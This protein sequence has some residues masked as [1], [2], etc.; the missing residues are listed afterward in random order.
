MSIIIVEHLL[1]SSNSTLR[2]VPTT[3]LNWTSSNI[4]QGKSLIIDSSSS[5]VA[6]G[7]LRNDDLNFLDSNSTIYK[8]YPYL[9]TP[10]ASAYGAS[11]G[12]HIGK[13]IKGSR[14]SYQS[15]ERG[16]FLYPIGPG[17]SGGNDMNRK[18]IGG[19]GGGGLLLEF[20]NEMKIDGSIDVSGNSPLSVTANNGGGGGGGGAGGSLFIYSPLATLS[21]NGSLLANGGNGSVS[22]T[23]TFHSGSG[24]GGAIHVIVCFDNFHGIME[25]K[26]GLTVRFPDWIPNEQSISTTIY[27]AAMGLSSLS[28]TV[29]YLR[30]LQH[31]YA[32]GSGIVIRNSQTSH[33]LSEEAIISSC[34]MNSTI[35]F[36]LPSHQIELGYVSVS[37]WVS[38]NA[39]FNDHSN[40]SAAIQS[41]I[42]HT[43]N[44]LIS[45]VLEVQPTILTLPSVRSLNDLTIHY[46][47]CQ[48]GIFNITGTGNIQIHH[49]HGNQAC[50]I[51]FYENIM[52]NAG[53]DIILD[54]LVVAFND[55]T[56]LV[57][58][59]SLTI[60]NGASLLWLNNNL[61]LFENPISSE[62]PLPLFIENMKNLT[63]SSVTIQDSSSLIGSIL[64]IYASFITIARNSTISTTGRGFPGGITSV[65]SGEV[66]SGKGYGRGAAGENGGNGG[67][68]GGN[69][70]RGITGLYEL[71]KLDHYNGLSNNI[72]TL[73]NNASTKDLGANS[74]SYGNIFSPY[75]P[76]SGGG[77]SETGQLSV[78]GAGGGVIYISLENDLSLDESCSIEANGQFTYYG[79]GGGAGGSIWIRHYP[80]D[81]SSGIEKPSPHIVYDGRIFGSGQIT[82][83]GGATCQTV[84][85]TTTLDYPGGVGGGGRIRIEKVLAE[86]DGL[87]SARSGYQNQTQQLIETNKGGSVATLPALTT[88]ILNSSVPSSSPDV[89]DVLFTSFPMFSIQTITTLGQGNGHRNATNAKDA[90]VK[91]YWFIGYRGKIA[92]SYQL[93]SQA[94]ATEVKIALQ[95]LEYVELMNIGIMKRPSTQNG[96]IWSITFYDFIDM[97]AP[98]YVDYYQLYCTQGIPTVKV[99]YESISSVT[100]AMEEDDSPMIYPKEIMLSMF[101]LSNSSILGNNSYGLWYKPNVFR[102]Y[103]NTSVD[104]TSQLEKLYVTQLFPVPG[105]HGNIISLSPPY[106]LKSYIPDWN[107]PTS[108]PSMQPSSQPSGIPTMQPSSQPTRQPSSQPSMV[109]STQPSSRPSMQPSTQP[110]S[111]PSSQP[112]TQPTMQPSTQPTSQPSLQPFS[113][114]TS[115]PSR[116]PTAQPTRQPSSQPSMV[117][118]AQPSSRPSM[119]PSTQPSSRPSSQPSTHPT[120]QP[121]TQPTSQPSRQPF[122]HPTGQPSA[123]PVSHPTGQP[124]SQPTSQPSLQPFSHPT[125]QPSNQ[126]SSRPSTQPSSQP[127]MVPSA[128]P[129]SRPSMQPSSQPSMVPSTQPSSLP[130]MIPS[131]QPS[132]NPTNPS[133]QPSSQVSYQSFF[134]LIFFYFFPLA[135]KPHVPTEFTG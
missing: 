55:N 38:L 26:G 44:P 1:L 88:F 9:G 32:G 116:Q 45:R 15:M 80:F 20:A 85:C 16:N 17:G 65:F 103:A 39:I 81:G 41:S 77:S 36:G 47:D 107:F 127:S 4:I 34:S 57:S 74:Q 121:S 134:L 67:G 87:I 91:G 13:G 95:S 52:V 130:S 110:S 73:L 53:S 133:G 40:L 86:Y 30:S 7:I 6:K 2:F 115:Q 106:L 82:A 66:S 71:S 28:S 72:I 48:S 12:S 94:T 109:P 8:E 101:L 33:F 14:S 98:I 56:D 62:I 122:S 70:G 120:M 54:G 124:S 90:I 89:L 125:G 21:G 25:A 104:L 19:E 3:E 18:I 78:G 63:F 97:V 111:R 96:W 119:Q 84:S 59:H 79:G 99:D 37:S 126:P 49:F 61:S 83:N 29:M 22:S 10:S 76:G 123:Q 24:G 129:T 118:S 64:S 132:S 114:P 100:D 92:Y 23:S 108:Q 93:S 50:T 117:P 69:G 31:V 112:S 58:G 60:Q 42:Q 5:V 35:L 135:H 46:L 128:Q 68:N 27:Q 102:I 105:V 113:R 51:S 75:F 131:G 11:G 43:Q